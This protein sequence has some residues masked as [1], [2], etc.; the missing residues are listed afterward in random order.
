MADETLP[1][2][3]PA[4][5]DA[6]EIITV[7]LDDAVVEELRSFGWL[8]ERDGGAL[9][10]SADGEQGLHEAMRHHLAARRSRPASE[11]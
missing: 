3:A 2:P 10:L 4:A 6:G 7:D 9:W 8:E 11:L 1:T 5:D